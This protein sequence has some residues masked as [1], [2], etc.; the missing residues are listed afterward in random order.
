M[1]EA[2]AEER[3]G[4]SGESLSSERPSFRQR[5]SFGVK[6]I[7]EKKTL[8]HMASDFRVLS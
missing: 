8:N 5:D 1:E 3:G 2:G 4:L 6:H 7:S